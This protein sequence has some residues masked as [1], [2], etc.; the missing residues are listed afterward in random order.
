MLGLSLLLPRADFS[1]LSDCSLKVGSELGVPKALNNH[2]TNPK[3][4]TRRS[5]FTMHTNIC[6]NLTKQLTLHQVI[7]FP[8]FT[9]K[10]G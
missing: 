3:M 4:I 7:G 9:E 10:K 2:T 8:I 6:L 1:A 5:Y